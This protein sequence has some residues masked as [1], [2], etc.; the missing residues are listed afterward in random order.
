M[1][2]L[3]QADQTEILHIN[4]GELLEYKGYVHISVGYWLEYK[5]S[6]LSVLELKDSE[7]TYHNPENMREGMTG[8]DASTKTFRFEAIAAGETKLQILNNFRGEI[9][10][11]KAWKIIVKD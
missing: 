8:G 6:N 11:Q 1:Y 10:S 3:N 2:N 7:T 9:E 5:I 4:K